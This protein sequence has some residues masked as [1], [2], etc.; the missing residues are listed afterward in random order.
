MSL[1]HMVMKHDY[2]TYFKEFFPNWSG[3]NEESH[4]IP[5]QNRSQSRYLNPGLL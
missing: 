1:A 3:G 2:Q 5:N 4:E